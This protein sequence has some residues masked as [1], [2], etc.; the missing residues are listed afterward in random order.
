MFSCKFY[1]WFWLKKKAN[2]VSSSSFSSSSSS[3]CSALGDV[4]KQKQNEDEMNLTT[5]NFKKQISELE[6]KVR[7]LE[8]E[9]GRY[10]KQL[11]LLEE[12]IRQMEA[13]CQRYLKEKKILKDDIIELQRKLKE[14][15]SRMIE[16]TLELERTR[17]EFIRQ[18]QEWK[19]FQDDL[20]TTVRVANDLK[21][22]AQIDSEILLAKNKQLRERIATLENEI[23]RL[24]SD[25][26]E[27]AKSLEQPYATIQN[28]QSIDTSKDNHYSS[29]PIMPNSSHI[30]NFSFSES[31]SSI[32]SP[33]KEN[34]FKSIVRSNN[35]NINNNNNWIEPRYAPQLSVRTIIENIENANKKT[36]RNDSPSGPPLIRSLSKTSVKN[37]LTNINDSTHA[38]HMNG[39]KLTPMNDVYNDKRIFNLKQVNKPIDDK[40][41]VNPMASDIT[42]DKNV[43][44]SISVCQKSGPQC[45]R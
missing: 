12:A 6:N 36:K 7:S 1:F 2:F 27:V 8:E 19:L 45:K 4:L 31:E 37:S 10:C 20:L 3:S 23:A 33:E 26:V 39:E 40:N 5:N 35:N 44:Q 15:N 25:N 9:K 21:T 43:T 16:T 17:N 42:G 32:G 22:G 24:K 13:K 41:E 28:L 11:E 18:E 29:S 30:K 14:A 38:V 34:P